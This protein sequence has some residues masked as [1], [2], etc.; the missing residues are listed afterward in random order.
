MLAKERIDLQNA[1]I[2]FDN[3]DP[4][5]TMPIHSES[6]QEQCKHRFKIL[7]PKTKKAIQHGGA[8]GELILGC[9]SAEQKSEWMSLLQII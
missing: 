5:K 9:S 2:T 6:Q 4:S 3:S 7:I 1:I 8:Y